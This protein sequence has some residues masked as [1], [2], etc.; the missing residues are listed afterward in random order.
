[1]STQNNYYQVFMLKNSQIMKYDSNQQ[2]LRN[3][4]MIDIKLRMFAWHKLMEQRFVSTL[5]MDIPFC[6]S[7]RQNVH[8]DGF[9]PM[10]SETLAFSSFEN[11]TLYPPWSATFVSFLQDKFLFI[12]CLT[13]NSADKDSLRRQG[14]LRTKLSWLETERHCWTSLQDDYLNLHKLYPS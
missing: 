4:K 9:V 5:L 13:P 7:C 11:M 14:T 12:Q 8:M 2:R 10:A 1:M 6:T 3:C